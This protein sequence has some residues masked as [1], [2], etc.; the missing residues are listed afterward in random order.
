MIYVLAD[1]FTGAAEAAAAGLQYGL[2]SEVHTTFTPDSRAGLVALDTNSRGGTQKEAGLR[3]R[4]LA[5]HLTGNT[6][7]KKVDSVLRGWVLTEI[8]NL[9]QVLAHPRIF[10]IPANPSMGRVVKDGYYYIGQIPLHE[11]DFAYDP[12]HPVRSSLVTEM[13][14]SEPTLDQLHLA[15][16]G[17][18]LPH[19]GVL[20]GDVETQEDLSWWAGMLDA[21]TLPAGASEFLVSCLS[22][23]AGSP[24][25]KPGP[26]PHPST[27]SNTLFVSGSS[28][29]YSRTLSI[30]FEKKG[31][32][33]HR[34]PSELIGFSNRRE[35]LIEEW[36]HKILDSL[37]TFHWARVCIDLPFQKD[38][39]TMRSL[40]DCLIH[41]VERVLSVGFVDHLCMEGGETVSM[42]VRRS[43]WS[44]LTVEAAWA[45][46]V[47]SLKEHKNSGLLLTTKPGS[48]PWPDQLLPPFDT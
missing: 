4:L 3:I 34:I 25:G 5:P 16:P 14:R 31:T 38:Q 32:P 2:R 42:F 17:S 36:S 13:L 41:T 40:L 23:W 24:K 43:G 37:E 11:S 29:L 28:S 6:I 35:A 18:D 22:C 9:A 20:I 8:S 7:F 45:R 26:L 10:L 44:K 48:Y 19:E 27:F 21:Q 46:G 47:V 39:K 33:V 12:S 1:D 30:D 15:K